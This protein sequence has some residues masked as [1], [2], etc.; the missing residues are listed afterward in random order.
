MLHLKTTQSGERRTERPPGAARPA[1]RP[2]RGGLLLALAAACWLAGGGAARAQDSEL[3][4]KLKAAFLFN[5]INF[6]EWPTNTV[7]STNI[8]ILVGCLSED[9][10]AA[11]FA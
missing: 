1:R 11:V 8:T 10:A 2:A 9:P 7:A 5:F 4:Y 3:E 6:V